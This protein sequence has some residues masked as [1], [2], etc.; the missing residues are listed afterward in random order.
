[1]MCDFKQSTESVGLKIHPNKTKILSNQSTNKRKEVEINN[2]K[3][4]IL[5]ACESAKYLGQTF[6]LQHQETAEI[7]NRIRAAWAPFCR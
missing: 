2:F 1:M 6:T 5:S 4:E 7:K 3:V